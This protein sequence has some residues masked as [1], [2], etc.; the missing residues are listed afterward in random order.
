MTS[1]KIPKNFDFLKIEDKWIKKWKEDEVYKFDITIPDRPIYSIDTPP[2]FTSGT[3][4]MGHILNHT[5]ID[6]AARFRRMI[7]YNVYFP[8]GFDCHGL[9]TELKVETEYKISKDDRTL[10]LEKCIEWTEEAIAQMKRQFDA[11][12]YST[13]W[14]L[15]YKTMDKEYLRL[16]QSSL[17]YFYEKG[18]LYR[19]KFPIH[20]CVKCSTALA[21]QEVGYIDEMGH[22]WYIK[23][24]LSDGSGYVTIATTRPEM[25]PA[26]VAVLVHPDDSRHYHLSGKKVKL[27]IFEREVPIILD[28]EVDMEFGTGIVY[29]CTFGDETDI[30]WQVEYNLPVIQV[31]DEKGIMTEAAAKYQ[32]LAIEEAREKIIKDLDKLGMIEKIEELPHRIIV[33]TERS[34]CLNPIEY[35]PIEQWFIKV[36]S[37]KEEIIEASEKMN[38]Y[39]SHM[40]KRL[41]DWVESLDWDWVISRQRVF[42]TPIPFWYCDKCNHIIAPNKNNLPLDPNEVPPPVS[43]CPKCDG[44]IIATK[45]VCDCWVDSSV[46]PLVISKWETN[47]N[48]F[49]RTY[50][51]TMRPQGYEIIRTWAFYTIFRCLKLTNMPCFKDLMINGMVAGTDGRKMSKSYGNVVAPEEPLAK[52][53]A[54]ALRQWAAMGTLGDDYPYTTKELE[55]SF[56]FLRKLWNACRFTSP[57]LVD[58]EYKKVKQQNLQLTNI[59]TWILNKF[60]EVINSTKKDLEVY[61][62][63]D[64]LTSFR[65]FFWHNFCDDYLEAVKYRIYEKI[66][67]I[68]LQT[69][70][71]VLYFIILNS[72]KIFAPFAP[73]ITEELYNLIFSKHEQIPS[74]HLTPWPESF[75]NLNETAV[76]NGERAIDFIK[77]LRDA[78]AKRRLALSKPI[79]ALFIKGE[80]DLL[81]DLEMQKQVIAKTLKIEKLEFVSKILEPTVDEIFDLEDPKI[82][83]GWK[84]K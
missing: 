18:W 16:V 55:Y 59:D 13:Y 31:I 76:T 5:W 44:N 40:I 64:S 10:F 30:K 14:E 6:I 34:S 82:T 60:N 57:N 52:Y 72:L 35:L 29:L 26:C 68:D 66:S 78:K 53:G 7:G 39:P 25:T 61:N 24:P 27:P 62:F 58:F 11:I 32:G 37:F 63:R 84:L 2:P 41:L 3:L 43:K 8:Q 51:S 71:Y 21:K 23:M 4:H 9:P 83:I 75:K 17:L 50:P 69:A 74:I 70:Q 56:R 49:K 36:K 46:T 47:N 20:W 22:L 73:F 48:Y 19:K 33:H 28:S 77:K 65:Q 67:D 54:D 79:P 12:A 38:W 42:G 81:K 80:V 15:T 1:F 45:D